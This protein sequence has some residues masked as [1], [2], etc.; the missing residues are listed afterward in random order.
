M[1]NQTIAQ[2]YTDRDD[3]FAQ[4]EPASLTWAHVH[5]VCRSSS[6]YMAAIYLDSA[7]TTTHERQLTPYWCCGNVWARR[8][9]PDRHLLGLSLHDRVGRAQVGDLRCDRDRE[10]CWLPAPAV[11]RR[12]ERG[13]AER[14]ALSQRRDPADERGPGRTFTLPTSSQSW[15]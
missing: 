5:S 11:D 6:W 1:H 4:A 7:D 10:W 15:A 14:L 3:T 8:C 2:A 9:V 13:G 12:G